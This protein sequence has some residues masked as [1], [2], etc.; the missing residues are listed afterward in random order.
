MTP[1]SP[2]PGD[3][4]FDSASSLPESLKDK[5]R[6]ASSKPVKHSNSGAV[7]TA[8]AI[9]LQR[10]NAEGRNPAVQRGPFKKG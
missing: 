8:A 1:A 5:L 10:R 7:P 9:A 6:A 4:D 2:L 3:P